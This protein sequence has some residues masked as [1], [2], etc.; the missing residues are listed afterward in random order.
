MNKHS[1]PQHYEIRL[2][3]HLHPRWASRFAGLSITHEQDGTTTLAGPVVDQAALHGLLRNVRDL[4][5]PLLSLCA[6]DWG[7][8]PGATGTV[9]AKDNCSTKENIV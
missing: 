5:L 4:G 3:G 1:G 6:V 9:A 2:K 8:Q 7:Q